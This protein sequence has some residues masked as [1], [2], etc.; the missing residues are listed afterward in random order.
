MFFIISGRTLQNEAKKA[1][2]PWSIAKE[3]DTFA[4]VGSF[5][6]KSRIPNAQNVEIWLKVNGEIRQKGNT[7]DQIFQI[8]QLIEYITKFITLEEG[9]ILL[10]G[11]PE[12][13][14]RVK[15]G[16]VLVGGITGI[17]ES[18]IEFNVADRKRKSKL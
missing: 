18:K 12:G 3:S 8:P 10:T 4:P 13:V 9:D 17:E 11:T 5:I 6:P 1:N 2:L 7:S 15:A 14:S 16:D